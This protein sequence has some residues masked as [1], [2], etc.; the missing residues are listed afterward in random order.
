MRTQQQCILS[1][2]VHLLHRL[3]DNFCLSYHQSIA[4]PRKGVQDRRSNVLACK[5]LSL[6]STRQNE[7]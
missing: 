6:D 4:Q 5:K 1:G 2:G 7:T 3:K